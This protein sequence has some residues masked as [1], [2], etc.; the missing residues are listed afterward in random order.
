MVELDHAATQKKPAAPT[1]LR[2]HL[3]GG[4]RVQER[5][6]Y[7]IDHQPPR[8]WDELLDAIAQQR[9]QEPGLD[10]IEI[11]IHPDSVDRETDA[12]RR[13][14]TWAREHNLRTTMSFPSDKAP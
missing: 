10:T 3:L 6:F 7:V 9:K 11:V 1:V 5:R 2:V 8:T 4:P 14:E 12:V 13:L